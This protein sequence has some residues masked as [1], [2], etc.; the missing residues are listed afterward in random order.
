MCDTQNLQPVEVVDPEVDEGSGIP[1]AEKVDPEEEVSNPPTEE[2]LDAGE[3][4]QDSPEEAKREQENKAEGELSQTTAP[5]HS[6]ELTPPLVSI[7]KGTVQVQ[8][9]AKVFTPLGIFPIL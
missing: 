5:D 1:P 3:T 4:M 6:N 8:C 9:L 2:S 7:R